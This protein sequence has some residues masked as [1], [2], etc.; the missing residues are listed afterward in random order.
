[1]AV[2]DT[3]GLKKFTSVIHVFCK[4]DKR[5]VQVDRTTI[6]AL[7]NRGCDSITR[8]AALREIGEL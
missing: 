7:V 4:Q 3:A 8:P 2:I 1:M 5:I 6:H